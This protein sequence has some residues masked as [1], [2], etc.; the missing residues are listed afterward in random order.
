[1][2]KHIQTETQ[3]EEEMAR[4]IL[5]YTRDILYMD[6]RYLSIALAALQPE[7]QESLE[8]L[9]TDGTTL[10]FAPGQ[11]IRVFR[12]NE[13][14]LARLY[15][16][17]VFHCLFR[18]LWTR[19][20]RDPRLWG[21]ACDI[22]VEYTID[23]MEKSSTKRIIGWTRQTV[24]REL[25]EKK[26]GVS[27]AVV[28]RFLAEREPEEWEKLHREFFAD[29][30]RYWP[31]EQEQPPAVIEVGNQ[32]SKI[33]RQTSLEQRQRGQN[34]D[35]GAEL[36]NAQMERGKRRQSYREFLDKFSVVREEISL[37]PEEF[38]INFYSYGLR[39]YGDMPL[40]EPMESRETK[41]IQDFVIV[42]D[43]S[44][45][46]S[47]E[48]VR[49]FLQETLDILSR[50]NC[51]FH[52]ARLHILQCDEK[53]Q[54]DDVVDS[55]GDLQ[56]LFQNFSIAGGGGTDF[57]PA[58][59][60]IDR[61]LSEGAFQNLCGML[62]FTDGRGTYPVKPPRYRTAFLFLEDF[63]EENVPP[64]AMR[65]RLEPEDFAQIQGNE[66]RDEYQDSKTG[67]QENG[68][69]ISFPG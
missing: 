26:K 51:F 25:E 38:D 45:S 31:R 54:R 19:G 34:P 40:I 4:K 53:V 66:E 64:W 16:H 15:L 2:G 36:L 20:G 61:L 1:M 49:S 29:D 18:H 57:R 42:V 13:R 52:R 24:Y 7:G 17:T 22:A 39:V 37:D 56:R 28:Y 10:Y 5:E 62:Y 32:W 43:T 60:Y 65:L 9:A 33:A 68:T 35:R 14:Y 58:F 3:W 67:N 59:D 47:G 63:Q 21:L 48:L 30:H 55:E 23:R 50:R 46:T 44:Y 69:G 11:L 41:K 8:T 6:M 12:T 27:A